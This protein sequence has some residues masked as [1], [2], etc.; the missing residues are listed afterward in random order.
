[1]IIKSTTPTAVKGNLH[2]FNIFTAPLDVCSI[3]T[4]TCLAPTTKSIAPPIP[5][6]FFP[7]IIQLA[8]FPF[9]STSNA[10][11]TVASTCPPLIIP[12]E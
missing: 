7:G 12:K 9:S 8:R 6:T 10:P 3:A 11:R 4:I 1:M 2:S 5:G